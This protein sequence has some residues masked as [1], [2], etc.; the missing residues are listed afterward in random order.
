MSRDADCNYCKSTGKCGYE[1]DVRG[2]YGDCPFRL[3]MG[4][5]DPKKIIRKIEVR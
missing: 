2:R 1:K 3:A 5:P 4:E